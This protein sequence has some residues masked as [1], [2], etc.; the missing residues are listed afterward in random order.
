MVILQNAFQGHGLYNYTGGQGHMTSLSH[1]QV[2]SQLPS[3]L[4]GSAFHH[5]A[6]QAIKL[7]QLQVNYYINCSG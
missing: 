5:P 7:A 1:P 6:E 2:T 3:M 4:A